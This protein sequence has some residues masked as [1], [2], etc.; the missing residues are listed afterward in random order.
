MMINKISQAA[1]QSNLH[2]V[3]AQGRKLDKDSNAPSVKKAPVDRSEL[4]AG[5][6]EKSASHRDVQ[7]L[8]AVVDAAPEV[9]AE[10]V[11]QAQARLASG[12][13]NTQSFAEQL[14]SKL[15]GVV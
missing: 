11:A 5:G 2:R 13:Y 6:A 7:I 9:R 3:D 4:S 8:S 12:F 14:A 15:V 1:V 10:K